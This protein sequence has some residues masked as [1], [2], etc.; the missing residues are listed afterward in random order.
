MNR[1]GIA[2][3]AMLTF[4]A[5]YATAG[6]ACPDP[7]SPV[8]VADT[9]VASSS[10]S[11]STYVWGWKV[12]QG[13]VTNGRCVPESRHSAFS[14][15]EEQ[16]VY[17]TRVIKNLLPTEYECIGGDNISSA[18]CSTTNVVLTQKK[19]KSDLNSPCNYCTGT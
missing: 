2:F 19:G 5:A 4:V 16:P 12:S 13:S 18:G 3:G 1:A 9:C 11:G 10:W 7:L 6:I 17:I 8:S 15:V 14:C